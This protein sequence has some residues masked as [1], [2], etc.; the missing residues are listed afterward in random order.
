MPPRRGWRRALYKFAPH[1]MDT[2]A[3]KLVASQRPE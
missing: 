3:H 1:R 2:A